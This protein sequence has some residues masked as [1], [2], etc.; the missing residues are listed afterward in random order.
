MILWRAADVADDM[1]EKC[2]P[3]GHGIVFA[4][5]RIAARRTPSATCVTAS[6][7]ERGKVPDEIHGMCEH[8]APSSEKGTR[9]TPLLLACFQPC[10]T[11]R[12][13]PEKWSTNSP[14]RDFGVI[15]GCRECNSANHGGTLA[16]LCP[17]RA[18]VGQ[19]LTKLTQVGPTMLEDKPMLF[20][21]G[22]RQPG[23][24][25]NAPGNICRSF[26]SDLPP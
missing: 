14:E 24:F 3:A 5:T 19:H 8:L 1:L 6:C 18:S 2:S 10:F 20:E 7:R 16:N 13:M 4:A 11:A 25:E 21:F 22:C 17:T 15:S 26:C 9:I 12:K 23:I